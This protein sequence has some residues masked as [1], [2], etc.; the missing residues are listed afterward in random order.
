MSKKEYAYSPCRYARKYDRKRI[1][2]RYDK[3]LRRVDKARGCNCCIPKRCNRYFPKL[4][5]RLRALWH[6]RGSL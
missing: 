4:I 1:R 5:V 6:N 3:A 2:C